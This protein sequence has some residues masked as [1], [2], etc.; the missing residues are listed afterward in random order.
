LKNL[1]RVLQTFKDW[2]FKLHKDL[3]VEDNPMI[4]FIPKSKDLK[5]E[6]S[7]FWQ[8]ITIYLISICFFTTGC[9][10]VKLKQ[11]Q[12]ESDLLTVIVG[13]V[14][15][16][17]PVDGPLIVAAYSNQNEKKT[18]A[19]YTISHDSGEFELMVSK[20]DY[21]VFAYIDQNSNLIYDEGEL[22]GQYG[23]PTVVAA[24]AGG[25]VSNINIVVSES[26]R[27]I[28]WRTGDKIAAER[29]QKLYSRLAGAIVDLDDERFSEERGSQGFWTPNAFYRTFGGTVFFLEEYDPRKIPI[30]FIHGAGGTPKGWKFF[31][32]NIDRTR[33]QPWFF[34]YPSGARIRSMSNLLFWKLLNLQAKYKFDT[35]YITAHSMGGLVARSFIQDHSTEFP[36]VTL[37][38]SLAT[39][40]GGDKMAEYGVKQSPAVIPCWID[41]QPEGDLIQSLYRSKMPD[42]V[43]YYMFFGHQGNRSPFSSNND[44]TIALSSLLDRRPQAEAKMSYAF[45]EDHTS[46]VSSKE[47]LEQFN[48]I[49]NTFDAKN[50]AL[51]HSSVGYIKLNYTYNTPGDMEQSWAKLLL[52]SM[53]EKKTET[54]VI[55]R[56][57]DN[58]KKLGP[59]PSGNYEASIFANGV[60]PDT[61]MVPISVEDN[62]SNELNFVLIP[63]GVLSGYI[64]TAIKQENKFLGM[65]GWEYLPEDNTIQV[66]SVRLKGGGIDRTLQASEDN[67]FNWSAMEISRT[68]YC[69]RGYLRFFGLSAGEYE[70]IVE[71]E[72]HKVFVKKRLLVIPGKDRGLDFFELTPE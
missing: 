25:V 6:M 66:R 63:D 2:G 60:R 36:Y 45:N 33:F 19:H 69:Y 27:P 12:H 44:G 55:L 62:H 9:S 65:P 21:Y 17:S 51:T 13:Y 10:L 43:N 70:L 20:G 40:W 29:P 71:A 18:I 56:P 32:D 61:K 1:E 30:L 37:F 57:G 52:R 4:I 26:S 48:A 8:I 31:V 15:A 7:T 42:K 38:I 16:P 59:F 11:D 14:S 64:S 72:G 53:D 50:R 39:P 24:P 22:A 54:V 5:Y 68:D 34:S 23:D 47:V 35:L 58:G 49:I 28:D 67:R 3:I 41:M 46:I